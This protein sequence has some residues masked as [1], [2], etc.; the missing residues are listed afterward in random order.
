MKEY[1]VKILKEKEEE[2][3]IKFHDEEGK[4]ISKWKVEYN[5]EVYEIRESEE[6]ET[7]VIEEDNSSEKNETNNSGES[8]K[9]EE[10]NND[11]ESNGNKKRKERKRMRVEERSKA[12][13]E[14]LKELSILV[15]E[16]QLIEKENSKNIPLEE[17]F[18]RAIQGEQRSTEYWFDVGES[19]KNNLEERKHRL[20]K[21]EKLIRI[22]IYNKLEKYLKEFSRNAIQHKI[23][24]AEILI[25]EISRIEEERNN[26]MEEQNIEK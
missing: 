16:E 10:S 21:K 6:K 9:E 4:I 3:K 19:F 7:E 13:R 14:L 2:I 24:R 25:K 1:Q 20:G 8:E 11:T 17:L 22:D 23:T 15:R 12:F 18:T 26:I 5:I